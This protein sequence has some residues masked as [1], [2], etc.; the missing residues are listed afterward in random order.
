MDDLDKIVLLE[1]ELDGWVKDSLGMLQELRD[2]IAEL[3]RILKV[4]KEA[5]DR[6]QQAVDKY[7]E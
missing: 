4:T 3:D 7:S 6:A 2:R 5:R 1:E